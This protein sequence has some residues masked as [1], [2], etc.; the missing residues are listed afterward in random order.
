[1]VEVTIQEYKQKIEKLARDL[2]AA[3]AEINELRN[4]QMSGLNRK[5]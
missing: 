5:I 3:K 2:N 4:L 1:M